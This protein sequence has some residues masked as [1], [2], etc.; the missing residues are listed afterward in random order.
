LY[1]WKF[2]RTQIYIWEKI[3]SATNNILSR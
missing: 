1:L 2:M 3:R